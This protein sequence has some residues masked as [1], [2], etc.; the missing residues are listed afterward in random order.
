MMAIVLILAVTAIRVTTVIAVPLTTVRGLIAV[1]VVA[2]GR[3][4]MTT[5]L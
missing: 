4:V 3:A 2:V 1:V 5:V